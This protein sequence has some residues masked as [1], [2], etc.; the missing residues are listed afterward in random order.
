MDTETTD[1]ILRRFKR[2][3]ED[4]ALMPGLVGDIDPG[5]CASYMV[6]GQ[7]AAADYQGVIDASVPATPEECTALV[8]DLKWIGY[9]PRFIRKSHARHYLA[10]AAA[11]ETL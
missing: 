3:G 11:L 4:I 8:F 1:I 2:T 10:R 5:T 7:H 6:T 9:N